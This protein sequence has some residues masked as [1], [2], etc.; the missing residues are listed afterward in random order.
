[1]II[2]VLN[3]YNLIP[4]FYD[5]DSLDVLSANIPEQSLIDGKTYEFDTSKEDYSC[6]TY[7]WVLKFGQLIS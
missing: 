7:A 4:K 2:K 1:M 6:G 5:F 3:I